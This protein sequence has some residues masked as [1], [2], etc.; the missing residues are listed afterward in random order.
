MVTIPTNRKPT[1]PGEMLLEEF[2]KPMKITQRELS[3][4]LQIPYKS[5]N[6]MVNGKRNINPSTALRLSKAFSMSE[7]FWLN[8]QSRWDIY[9]ARQKEKRVLQKIKPFTQIRKQIIAA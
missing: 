2:L 8:L 1:H 5:I 7:D 9:L 4:I 6:E 3:S